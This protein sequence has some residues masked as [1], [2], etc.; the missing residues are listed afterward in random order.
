MAEY[1]KGVLTNIG[2]QMLA[3]SANDVLPVSFTKIGTIVQQTVTEPEIPDYTSVNAPTK[4]NITNIQ[5]TGKRLKLTAVFNTEDNQNPSGSGGRIR[6]FA[7]YAKLGSGPEQLFGACVCTSGIDTLST[8][9]PMT[10]TVSLYFE[11][12]GA[13][14]IAVTVEQDTYA[15]AQTVQQLVDWSGNMGARCTMYGSI[16]EASCY[17][18]E[19][20]IVSICGKRRH[21]LLTYYS[22]YTEE[23]KIVGVYDYILIT[24]LN[25]KKRNPSI[26]NSL[27]DVAGKYRALFFYDL[28]QMLN[29]TEPD[30]C[31]CLGNPQDP[32]SNPDEWDTWI[33]NQAYYH[34]ILPVYFGSEFCIGYNTKYIA[35]S[36]QYAKILKASDLLNG[37]VFERNIIPCAYEPPAGGAWRSTIL[38]NGMIFAA[39]LDLDARRYAFTVSNPDRPYDENDY[40]RGRN[41]GSY[42]VNYN[43]DF[44]TTNDSFNRIQAHRMSGEFI[45]HIIVDNR[46]HYVNH[47]QRTYSPIVIDGDTSKT[48]FMVMQTAGDTYY[49]LQQDG[50]EFK[51]CLLNISGSSATSIPIE[52]F[53]FDH[54]QGRYYPGGYFATYITG[55]IDVANSRILKDDDEFFAQIIGGSGFFKKEKGHFLRLDGLH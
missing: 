9:T 8:T 32:P 5:K 19:G 37:N 51:W 24:G 17:A 49:L 22:A 13:A 42:G 25:C 48:P 2:L 35:N 34:N 50:G 40:S 46:P 16:W 7:V 30:Y 26:P 38:D 43:V 20:D 11:F 18:K 12:A 39:Y 4:V 45:S 10:M 33:D 1:G 23:M 15:D 53:I 31:A 3:D 6:G 55:Q 28:R 29:A 52:E 14:N 54:S 47:S 44:F 27:L 21:M 36:Y 41:T